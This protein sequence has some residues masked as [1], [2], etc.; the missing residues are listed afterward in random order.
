MLKN[1]LLIKSG[2]RRAKGQSAAIAVLMLLAA[3]MLNIWLMLAMDYKQNFER[4]HEK[5]NSE[6]SIFILD[7]NNE[8]LKEYLADILREDSSVTGFYIS[9][10]LRMDASFDYNGGEISTEFIILPKQEALKRPIG[11]VQIVEEGNAAQGIYLPMLYKTGDIAVGKTIKI[12]TGSHSVSY[13]VG[14]FLNSVMAGSHNCSMCT[15]LLTEE[16]YQELGEKGYAVNSVMLSVRIQDKSKSEEFEASL[17]N[18]ISARYPNTR[19][20]SNSYTLVSAS[21]YISQMICSGIVSAMALFILLIALVVISSNIL[22]DIQENM[23]NFGTLKAAGYTGAQLICQLLLQYLGISILSAAA[24]IGVSYLL[25]PGVNLM[26]VSQTGIPYEIRFLPL[27]CFAVLGILGGSVTAAVLF[28]SWK[29]R[30]IEPVPALRQGVKT[31]NFKKNRIPLD[32]GSMPVNIALALKT[33][34]SNIRQNVI[35]CI[36]VFVLS[37]VVVFSGVM[38][39][40]MIADMTPFVNLVVGETA[41]SSISVTSEREE[42]FL[43]RM[44]DD[45][46]VE[47]IYLYSS[48]QV[49][50]ADG[51]E[52]TATMSDDFSMVNNQS[53]CV[54][55]RFP[56]YDNETAVAVKYA[57]QRGLRI[58]D[59]ITLAAEGAEEKYLICG[60][61]QIS[62]NLGKDCLLTRAGYE[63]M[64]RFQ[65]TCYYLNLKEGT[66]IDAFNEEIKTKM[67]G[68]ISTAV[69]IVSILDGTANVYVTLMKIIVVCILVLSAVVIAFVLYLLVRTMLNHKKQEYGILKALGYTTGQLVLQTALCFMPP[70]VLSMT[71]GILINSV[72]INPLIALFLGGIGILKCTFAI[73]GGFLAAAGAGMVVYA[74][75][76]TCVLSL[77]I[78]RI[79]P[80]V[81]LAGE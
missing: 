17:K 34:C 3:C 51:I 2:L 11:K 71:A 63:R 57:N 54:E 47:K 10:T 70:M 23:K 61:T 43:Q 48:I 46:R 49:R 45:K 33:A 1:L 25:F 15:L 64:G 35:I 68:G 67:Q 75:G 21:R 13:P 41:D 8:E 73:P 36:T 31:H 22:N 42:E 38:V 12:S 50:H 44:A 32:T 81:M 77:R 74:F 53:V 40:N 37:L 26:M 59:E 6:H 55:G 60:F 79:V 62:N 28:S 39:K 72:L 29:I 52:L 30:K 9:D 7:D 69:N 58:G 76:I 27:P 65:Q 5:L 16:E 20:L 4:C 19:I 18:K 80:R 56:K 14:G 66:D 24:G 78:R